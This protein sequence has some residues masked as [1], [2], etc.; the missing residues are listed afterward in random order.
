M[1]QMYADWPFFRAFL[2]NVSMTL[3][4]TD[5]AMAARYVDRLVPE[6][7]RHLFAAVQKEHALTVEQVLLVTGE[8]ELLGSDPVLL[9]TLRTRETYL[10]PL[11][12][13]QIEL[14]ARS[15]AG[16]SDP[17][18]SRALLLT[19]NGVAAGLRNTG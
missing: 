5:L 2:S 7:L 3:A 6:E 9:Q 14:L 16:E 17:L 19:V 4:K 18:L 8:S 15:R 13:L 12:H 10:E 11:H 1:R